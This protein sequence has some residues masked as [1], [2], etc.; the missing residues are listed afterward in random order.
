MHK[1][2]YVTFIQTTVRDGKANEVERHR[3]EQHHRLQKHACAH[4]CQSIEKVCS[5]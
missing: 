5:C 3:C 1:N 4:L 2:M